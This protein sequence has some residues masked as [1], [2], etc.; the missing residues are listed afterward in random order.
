[1]GLE[2]ASPSCLLLNFVWFFRLSFLWVGN[3]IFNSVILIL[4]VNSIFDLARMCLDVKL[5]F[6]DEELYEFFD[7]S[8][9]AVLGL[10]NLHIYE[11][12]LEEF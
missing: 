3:S 12:G 7:E 8:T 1:M 2:D 9:E 5:Y 6:Y 4:L 10:I 11:A